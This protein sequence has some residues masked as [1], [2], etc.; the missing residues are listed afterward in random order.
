MSIKRN[1]KNSVTW[2]SSSILLHNN[3]YFMSNWKIFT[4]SC[5]SLVVNFFSFSVPIKAPACFKRGKKLWGFPWIFMIVY[6]AIKCFL[7]SSQ[8]HSIIGFSSSLYSKSTIRLTERVQPYSF[9]YGY[10]VIP[11][12]LVETFPTCKF[13]APVSKKIDHRYI[14]L[15][16]NSQFY[17]DWSTYA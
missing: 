16:L 3:D 1:P 6:L 8:C 15:L 14:Y 7:F 2:R 10:P 5:G 12:T 17:W 4:E 13:A 11:V 9:A